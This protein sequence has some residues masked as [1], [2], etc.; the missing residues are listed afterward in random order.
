MTLPL[1]AKKWLL[2]ESKRQQQED[3]KTKKPFSLNSKGAVKIPEKAG[4]DPSYGFVDEFIEEAVKS[5]NEFESDQETRYNFWIS[6][7]SLNT[8]IRINYS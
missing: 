4:K 3:D 8:S 6:E 1:E 7:Y 5:S 2:N